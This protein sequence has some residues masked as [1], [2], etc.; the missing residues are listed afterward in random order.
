M[1][2]LIGQ[3]VSGSYSKG[4][5][6]KLDGNYDIE[7]LKIG[8]FV[9]IEGNKTK[10]FAM[11]TDIM[12][13]TNNQKLLNYIPSPND[14]FIKD[15]LTGT[16]VYGIVHLTPYLMTEEGSKLINDG[17]IPKVKKI[18]PHFSCVFKAEEKDIQEIFGKEEKTNNFF[19]IGFPTEMDI[20]VCINLDKFVQRSNA[21]F[22]K[23]GTGKSF[24]SRILLSGI[25][26]KDVA[27]VLIFDMHNEYGWQGTYE[28][29]E[30]LAS[31]KGLK[32]LFGDK[33]QVFTL[34]PQNKTF[35]LKDATTLEIGF[36]QVDV[37]DLELLKGELGLSEASMDHV[38]M[39]QREYEKD[40]FSKFCN[41]TLGDFEEFSARHGA[42]LGSLLAIQRKLNTLVDSVKYLK[43]VVSYDGIK[44]IL[45]FLISGKSVVLQFGRLNN[46]KSY[47]LA[48]NIITRHIHAAYVDL[49][50]KYL[51]D[52][53]KYQQPKRLVICIEEAHKFLSPQVAKVSTFGTIARELRK[54][55]VTLFIID[56]RPSG[57]DSEVL[58]QIGTRATLL[59]N[60][61][62][63][64]NAVFVG[65][66]GGDDLKRILSQLNP[67]QEVL[68]FGFAMPMP[69]VIRSRRYDENFYKAVTEEEKLS[70]EDIIKRGELAAAEL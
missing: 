60:D 57:I 15:V 7:N 26:K 35:T 11:V 14:V 56:Q 28:K 34:D 6:L 49:M 46:L 62:N 25:L 41:S 53:T 24:L 5:V 47:A 36:N 30:N 42:N 19:N 58:S 13:E 50:E 21:V 10:F 3:I 43:S 44:Q 67:T 66:S 12:L 69:I 48:S 70:K 8:E 22:G 27:S 68:M 45:N 52:R 16:S 31:A 9:I 39:F 32:Q 40:W 38:R 59:L 23:S 2:N 20:P 1:K 29:G 18:P 54:Y 55:N 51:L 63:D 64:I 4:L 61:E 65:E 33:V 17:S 37:E